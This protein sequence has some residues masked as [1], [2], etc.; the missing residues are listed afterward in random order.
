MPD[1]GGKAC[2]NAF[3]ASN[4]PADA[5]MPTTGNCVLG[6]SELFSLAMKFVLVVTYASRKKR[7]VLMQ[8]K[9]TSNKWAI[10]V[11]RKK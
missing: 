3:T 10:C 5:P 6:E 2:R 4:P 11:I 7:I 8:Y 1:L 9:S